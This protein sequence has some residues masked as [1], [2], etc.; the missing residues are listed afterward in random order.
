LLFAFPA[1]FENRVLAVSADE[2]QILV[3]DFRFPALSAF[4]YRGANSPVIFFFSA[5]VSPTC[6]L[7]TL[8]MPGSRV[9]PW[10]DFYLRFFIPL[11]WFLHE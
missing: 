10:L 9:F 7:Q 1:E 5:M 4:R 8:S 11:G 3:K 2:S 6:C